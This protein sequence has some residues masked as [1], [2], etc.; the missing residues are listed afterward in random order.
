MSRASLVL[1]LFAVLPAVSTA[2]TSAPAPAPAPAPPAEWPPLKVVDVHWIDTTVAACTDFSQFANG[3]W[4]AHDTIPAAYAS[5]G[6]TRDMSDRNEL[7]VRSVLDDAAAHRSSFPADSTPRKLGTFY[8]TCMD[9]TAIE[10]AG[11]TPIRP[12][13]RGID[14]VTTRARLVP[15]IAKLQVLGVNV[16]FRYSPDVDPHDAMHY[17]TWLYQ[18]GLGL[19]DRDYYFAQGAA[20]DSTRQAFVAHVAKMFRLAGQDS[21]AA[22]RAAADVMALET[23]LA[24]G[25]LTRVERRDPAKTDHPMSAAQLAALTPGL[26]WP[27]Y[28]RAIGL[29]VP[30]QKVNVAEPAFVKRVD[31]LLQA[32]P[33]ATW[34]AYLRYHAIASA[35]PWLSTPFVQEDFA[36]RSRFSGARA[37][38]PRWKRCLR[39]AD[40]D[41]GEA[42]GQ[43]YVAK[44]FPPEARARAR[45]VI[46]DIR[47]AFHERLLHLTWMSDSTRAQALDKLARMGEKI[48]YPD[49]WRDYSRLRVAEGPFVLN[50]AEANAFEWRRTVNRPGTPVDTTEWGITVPTVN[51]YY[52]PSKNEMVFPAGAL[53]P[54]TFDASA[55]DGAN[56]GSL[57]G[58]WA[59][60]ELTHGFD[61][62]GRHYDARGNLRDWWQPSDSVHFVEQAALV[63]QQFNEYIQVDTFHVNGKLTEG[64][65]IADWGG[66]LTAYDAL[67]S[68]LA[69]ERRPGGGLIEGYTPE[70]RYFIAYAQSWRGHDRPERL[71][72]RVTVDPHAPER[73]RINGPLSN[74]AA[75]AQAF[76]CKEGDPMV[77]PKEKVPSIW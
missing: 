52:D 23:S 14:S 22:G 42:L 76:G 11:A 30:V 60:H 67:E 51:A 32:A 6:V 7:V 46:D 17:L 33:L 77:R 48:G 4:L 8:A 13:L 10:A 25:S 54:Q 3:A 45:A 34:R 55:D 56:Y 62:E 66:L 37:L 5:S 41:V 1:M 47:T 63:E 36:F 73:W 65:N 44:T 61:D 9:S 71:R 72:T 20:S 53:M 75:F 28:F 69:R 74:I 24:R 64:E 70:Q 16:V 68:R 43:A 26:A 29:R 15:E 31:S 49:R 39:E 18:G 12:W 57:G 58:S 27:R 2:Q 21:A 38:L 35:A 19:P 50:V 40:G 59:G